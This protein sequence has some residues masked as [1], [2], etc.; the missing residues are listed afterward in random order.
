M[1]YLVDAQM[2]DHLTEKD[3]QMQLK[4]LDLIHPTSLQ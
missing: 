3:L 1:E 4:L 2:L